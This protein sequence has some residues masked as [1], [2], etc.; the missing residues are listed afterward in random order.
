M[1]QTIGSAVRGLWS[2]II[3]IIHCCFEGLMRDPTL[4]PRK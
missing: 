4:H 1:A 3:V 2:I